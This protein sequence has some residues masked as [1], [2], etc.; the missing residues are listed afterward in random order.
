MSWI[1]YGLRVRA[2]GVGHQVSRAMLP[3]PLVLGSIV[4]VYYASCDD[5]LRGRIYFA[6]IS[7]SPPFEVIELGVEPVL[8]LGEHGSFD[9]DGVNPSQ[10]FFDGPTLMMAYIGWKRHSASVP[11]T[12]VGGL[13]ASSDGGRSF[14]RLGE[15]LP[16]SEGEQYFRT[17]PFLYSAEGT[18][19]I[20]YIGGDRF[21]TADDGKRLPVYSL[22]Q[23]SSPDYRTW[24]SS[25]CEILA[26]DLKAGEIGFGRPVLWHDEN[27][28]PA[29]YLSRRSVDGYTLMQCPWPLTKP[30]PDL[31]A[32][33]P[34]SKDDWESQMTCFGAFCETD[35][36]E[37]MFYNGNGF[38]TTGFGVAAR[39]RVQKVPIKLDP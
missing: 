25:G 31:Q 19:N 14:E 29:L 11:Y 16:L 36:H 22:R 7:A 23:A 32:V 15:L 2:S 27:G 26:P 38:G 1:R 6:D 3:T 4:R 20:L 13:A 37:L 8:D 18:W 35:E 9:C 5:E 12:L 34:P 33:L 17:A 28:S 30:S 39:A 24:P 10:L 21:I